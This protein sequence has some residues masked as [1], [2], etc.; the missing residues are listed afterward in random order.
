MWSVLTIGF[1]VLI[2]CAV[3]WAVVDDQGGG[4]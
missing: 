2:I 3:I 4:D 1:A